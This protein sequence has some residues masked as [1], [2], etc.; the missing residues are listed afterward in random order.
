MVEDDDAGW[1]FCLYLNQVI[2]AWHR[3]NRIVV[4]DAVI[5]NIASETDID[6]ENSPGRTSGGAGWR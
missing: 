4:I 2:L 5:T 3:T 6:W 1:S